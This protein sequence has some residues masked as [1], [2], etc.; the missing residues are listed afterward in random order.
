MKTFD[1]SADGGTLEICTANTVIGL[2]NGIGDGDFKLH[3]YDL[4]EALP[5]DLELY[6]TL[7]VFD[8]NAHVRDSDCAGDDVYA[9]SEGRWWL[10]FDDLGNAYLQ[11][12]RPVY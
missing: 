2:F 9:L 5:D 1:I 6:A 8:G 3:I 4:D 11:G 12:P 7:H 10:L